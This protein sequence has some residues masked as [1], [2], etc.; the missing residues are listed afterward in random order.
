M[1]IVGMMVDVLLLFNYCVASCI[2]SCTLSGGMKIIG[3]IVVTERSVYTNQD[4][5]SQERTT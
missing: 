4:V 3:K 5:Y 2:E 1:N